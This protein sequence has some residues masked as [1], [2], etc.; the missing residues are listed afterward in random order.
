VTATWPCEAY[1]TEGLEVGAACFLSP[2]L[3]GRVC[4]TA[5]QCSRVM[6]HER[7]HLYRRLNELAADDTADPVYREILEG[8]TTPDELLGG[9]A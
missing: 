9:G 3:G 1:G 4:D 8:I 2:D 7:R 6:G 5:A